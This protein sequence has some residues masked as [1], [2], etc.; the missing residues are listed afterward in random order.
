MARYARDMVETS[1]AGHPLMT[2]NVRELVL[3]QLSTGHCNIDLA[4]KQMGVS[5][6]TLHRQLAR[7]GHTFTQILDAVRRELAS[8]YVA[9][10]HRSLGEVS[11]LLGF[12]NPSGF[13]RWY[14]RHFKSPASAA[15]TRARKKKEPA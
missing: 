14:R 7:E 3:G 2:D 10:K 12:A 13:S 5:R 6:R 4:A 1:F 8:R 15:G 9:D 11:E